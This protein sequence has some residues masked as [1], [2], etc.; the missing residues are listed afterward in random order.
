[1]D[2]ISLCKVN[3]IMAQ[4]ARYEVVLLRIISRLSAKI[5]KFAFSIGNLYQQ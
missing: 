5:V 4:M 1:M 3:E 2:G